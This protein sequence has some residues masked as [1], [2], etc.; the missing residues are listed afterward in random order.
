M[1]LKTSC[2]ES[3]QQQKMIL[4]EMLD[5][6]SRNASYKY[7]PWQCIDTK[8]NDAS[9]ER[10][11][12]L[13]LLFPCVA[14]TRLIPMMHCVKRDQLSFADSYVALTSLVERGRYKAYHLITCIPSTFV[15]HSKFEALTAIQ[16]N[17]EN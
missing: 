16:F 15:T 5:L 11:R 13:E 7:A 17:A 1:H 9:Y 14:K 12:P 8:I 6:V 4:Q 10:F 3:P 2:L